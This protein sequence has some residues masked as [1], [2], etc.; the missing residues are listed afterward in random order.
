MHRNKTKVQKKIIDV[1]DESGL[2]PSKITSV[3]CTQSGGIDNVGFSQ[4]D[5][6]DYLSQKRQKQLEKGDPQLMLSS[7]WM[8]RDTWLIAFGFIQGLE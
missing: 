4:Q 7:K 8:W 5:V 3:L 1:L 2:R 6:I